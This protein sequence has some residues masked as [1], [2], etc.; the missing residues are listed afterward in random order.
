MFRSAISV[1]PA[2]FLRDRISF[3]TEDCKEIKPTAMEWT[4][5]H[6]P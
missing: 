5:R 3:A 4:R 6:G 2:V 1:D